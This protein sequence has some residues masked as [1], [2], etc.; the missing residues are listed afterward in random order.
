MTPERWRRVEPVFQAALDVAPENRERFQT[1][2]CVGDEV[3]RRE[4][5]NLI[6]GYEAADEFLERPAAEP[7]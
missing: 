1:E 2:A 3:L 6:E 7:D 5:E 4:V